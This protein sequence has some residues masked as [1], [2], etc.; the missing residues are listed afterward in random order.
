MAVLDSYSKVVEQFIE[1][2]KIP[3]YIKQT[4]KTDLNG[5]FVFKDVSPGKYFVVVTFPTTIAM[6]KVFWQ[7]P[8]VMDKKNIEIELSNDNLALPP[9]DER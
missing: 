1:E 2:M 3:N 5:K 9:L 7:V 8:V 4:T 6:H